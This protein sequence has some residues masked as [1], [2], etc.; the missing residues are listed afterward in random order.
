MPLENNSRQFCFDDTCRDSLVN[1][2]NNVA[3]AKHLLLAKG[4]PEEILRYLDGALSWC[5]PLLGIDHPI[6]SEAGRSSLLLLHGQ[7][8]RHL[9]GQNT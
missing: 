4:S 8:D 3:I 7:R 6:L 5:K 9:V 1:A 2:F